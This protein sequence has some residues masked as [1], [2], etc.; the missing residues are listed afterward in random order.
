VP[1]CKETRDL[2][3]AT[4]TLSVAVRNPAAPMTAGRRPALGRIYV[5]VRRDGTSRMS[6]RY[7]APR[8]QG[9]AMATSLTPAA[10]SGNQARTR[11][12]ARTSSEAG[13]ERATAEWE[14]IG[15]APIRYVREVKI[16]LFVYEAPLVS[17]NCLLHQHT[18]LEKQRMFIFQE[19]G[20]SH[21]RGQ[22]RGRVQP[23]YVEVRS[24]TAPGPRGSCARQRVSA[25][26]SRCQ[27]H[28]VPHR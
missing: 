7:A 4:Q 13:R 23:R 24:C 10:V 21:K 18:H 17:R 22:R 1:R 5:Q 16:K 2:A 15:C 8:T 3:S 26:N 20:P 14:R 12:Y 11:P 6:L 28:P 9:S 19:I 27:P 25:A